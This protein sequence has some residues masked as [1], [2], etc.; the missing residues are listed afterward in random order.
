MLM[1]DKTKTKLVPARH[2]G[3]KIAHHHTSYGS[4]LLIIMLVAG[5]LM[6]VSRTASASTEGGGSYQTFAVVPGPP[7]TT[8]PQ[9]T[10]I[11]NGQVFTTS[12]QTIRGTC[13]AR[14]L[15]KIF[16]NEVLAGDTI[17]QNGSFSL[18]ID[19]FIGSNTIIARAYNTNDEV[20]PDSSAITIKFIPPGAQ[21]SGTSE[22]NP[23]GAPVGQFYVTTEAFYRG[24]SAGDSL[25]W[26]LTVNG[27]TPPY[28]VSVG[29][30]DGKTDLY[31][32]G[33]AGNFDIR[34]TYAKGPTDNSGYT[35]VINAT[36]QQGNKSFLQLV[37]LVNSSGQSALAN[38]DKGQPGSGIFLKIA[39]LLLA[40]ATLAV[41]GFWI[42]EWREKQ[43]LNRKVHLV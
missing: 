8:A 40:G 32:R 20:S 24:A 41:L 9:I 4:L 19:F 10:S 3:K 5:I 14:N 36:D 28:A 22:F 6:G 25:S 38:T 42:G 18:S 27:G 23:L 34:H 35:I 37:A 30:G 26:P 12:P 33:A 15:I 16:K 1:L 2:T 17:C 29:W 11:S 13:T 31:S 39:G 21:L 43:L 7:P